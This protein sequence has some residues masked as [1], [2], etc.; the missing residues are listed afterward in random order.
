[1]YNRQVDDTKF[2]PDFGEIDNIFF[3]ELIK[4]KYIGKSNGGHIYLVK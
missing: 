1:M 3:K 2:L 4:Y